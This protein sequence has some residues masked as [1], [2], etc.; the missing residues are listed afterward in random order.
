MFNLN[1]CFKHW[2]KSVL[3]KSVCGNLIR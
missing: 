3:D 1:N 2:V